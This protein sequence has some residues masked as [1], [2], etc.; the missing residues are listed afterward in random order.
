MT[1]DFGGGAAT[2]FGMSGRG[3]QGVTHS[4]TAGSVSVTITAAGPVGSRPAPEIHRNENNGLGVDN[5]RNT[6]DPGNN[7]VGNGES[8]TF[9]FTPT[10]AVID[11]LVFERG[12]TGSMEL[13]ADGSFLTSLSWSG[14]GLETLAIGVTADT[15]EF[16]GI[17]GS[18]RVR[19]LTIEELGSAPVPEPG[20]VALMGLGLGALGVAGLRRRRRS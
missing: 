14:R 7:R 16:R 15:L 10:V 5:G 20:T 18:F 13:W 3:R 12:S 4:F 6:T 11:S 1:L 9:A 8:L 17:S 2:A 19:A